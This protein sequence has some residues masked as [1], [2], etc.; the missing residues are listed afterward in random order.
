V[1]SYVRNG[2]SVELAHGVKLKF[3]DVTNDSR[4][5]VDEGG[6]C[7]WQG[8]AF[9][10]IELQVK[11]QT[12]RGSITTQNPDRTLLAHRV[13]LLGLYPPR[14]ESET[15][16]AEEYC[17]FFRVAD[18]APASAKAFANRAAALAAA[19]RYVGGHGAR[20]LQRAAALIFRRPLLAE[21]DASVLKLRK[22]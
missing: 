15:R 5:P 11:G 7:V 22:L 2:E 8:E 1:T 19:R 20:R 21:G 14:R 12:A 9:V 16:P 6:A 10:E 13:R 4:C 18:A 3:V 17:A